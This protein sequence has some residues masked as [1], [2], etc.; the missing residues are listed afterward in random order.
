MSIRTEAFIRCDRCG[1]EAFTHDQ[2]RYNVPN[3]WMSLNDHCDLCPA[4]DKA[5]A[6]FLKN[7]YVAPTTK[8][9]KS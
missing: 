8:E 3:G 5:F 7:N 2:D 1:F 6:E 9:V 4:C